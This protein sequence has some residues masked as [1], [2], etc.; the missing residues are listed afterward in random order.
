MG[1]PAWY[2]SISAYLF[3]HGDVGVCSF[4]GAAGDD[5]IMTTIDSQDDAFRMTG[6]ALKAKKNVVQNKER[7]ITQTK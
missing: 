7:E 3:E 6:D 5:I 4:A 2:L 1:A